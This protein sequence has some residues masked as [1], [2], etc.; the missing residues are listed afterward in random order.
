MSI[1]KTYTQITE[2]A[3]DESKNF[4]VYVRIKPLTKIER[5]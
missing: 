1:Q 4:Q 2:Q 5:I 3:Q